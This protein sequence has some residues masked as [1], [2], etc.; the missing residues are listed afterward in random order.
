MDRSEALSVQASEIIPRGA[1]VISLDFELMWG[2]RDHLTIQE[3]GKQVLGA[4]KIVPMLLNMFDG[5]RVG[6]TWA[7]VGALAFQ[8]VD[9]LLGSLSEAQIELLHLH[10]QDVVEEMKRFPEYYF[11][12]EL[13]QKI[14]CAERQEFACHTF[15]HLCSGINQRRMRF[16]LEAFRLVEQRVGRRATTVIFPRNMVDSMLSSE[17][18]RRFGY[19]AYRGFHNEATKLKRALLSF[20]PVPRLGIPYFLVKDGLAEIESSCFFRARG[21]ASFLDK[22]FLRK[23]VKDI[24]RCAQRGEMIHL[25]W[26]PHN[27][28][29]SPEEGLRV[30]K[31]VLEAYGECRE[32]F[33]M[34]SLTMADLAD[35]ILKH[36]HRLG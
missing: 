10:G 24:E 4:R 3:Y 30:V 20:A 12:P 5:Y 22:A 8:G 36:F 13:I 9:D 23:V 29:R 1:L 31:R 2:L 35:R 7:V 21:T 14:A 11:A 16:D 25:W 28:G 26:H 27:L 34:E 17:L 18:F 19:N 15:F 33:G 32:K 6:A